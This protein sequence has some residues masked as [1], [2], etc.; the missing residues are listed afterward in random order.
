MY[1][2]KLGAVSLFLDSPFTFGMRNE[3]IFNNK[4]VKID[5]MMEQT[6]IVSWQWSTTWSKIHIYLFYELCWN[7]RDCLAR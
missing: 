4:V 1:A 2:I 5:E 6:K 3:R 7:R